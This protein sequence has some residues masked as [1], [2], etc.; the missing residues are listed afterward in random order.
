MPRRSFLED[1]L[2]GDTALRTLL[3]ASLDS[4]NTRARCV[5]S[6]GSGCRFKSK[7]VSTPETL[8]SLWQPLLLPS[9]NKN[10]HSEAHSFPR[11]PHAPVTAVRG[12]QIRFPSQGGSARC[13][14]ER[15]T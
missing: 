11:Q 12:S 10:S 1:Q 13:T 8:G 5:A 4:F 9:H 15:W 14:F 7:C 6:S 2:D 3:D